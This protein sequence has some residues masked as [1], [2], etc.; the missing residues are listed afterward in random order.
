M[1][2]KLLLAIQF[3]DKDKEQAMK[4]ARLIA[5]LQSGFC[6][7]ADFMFVARFDCTQDMKT[8]EHVSR[9]FNVHHFINTRHRGAEW[10]HGCNSLWFGTMDYVY[11]MSVAKRIPE[12]KAVLTF[13]ADSAPLS[14]NWISELSRGWDEAKGKVYGAMQSNPAPHVNGNA[15]FS[16]DRDFL[17]WVTRDVGGCSP[18]AGWDF[19]LAS[20]FRKR[21]WADCPKMRSWWG[22]PT[23]SE[24]TFNQLSREGVVF[25][26]GVKNC[27]LV[28]H[29][30]NRFAV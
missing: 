6:E 10:P 13:E 23:M 15:L 14:P 19:V 11:T 12:Y 20:E 3:W 18:H 5:D 27:S 2:Q 7:A 28:E 22:Y 8:V 21:G 24:E 4:V 16:A 25:F 1:K 30:R 9:K 26:H 29:V 17:K